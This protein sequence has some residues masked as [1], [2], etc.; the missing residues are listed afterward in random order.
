MRTQAVER[1]PDKD[2]LNRRHIAAGQIAKELEDLQEIAAIL[3]ADKRYT[4]AVAIS[5]AR[6]IKMVERMVE[7]VAPNEKLKV[8]EIFGQIR[9][10]L[11]LTKEIEG[12]KVQS[13]YLKKEE[14]GILAWISRWGE[15]NEGK[16]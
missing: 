2:A 4:R 6:I 12:V 10:R 8:A 7:E 5:Y 15:K 13:E 1:Q 11:R 9:E 3:N 16:N 14:K